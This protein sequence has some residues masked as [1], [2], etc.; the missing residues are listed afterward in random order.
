MYYKIGDIDGFTIPVSLQFKY[1][2]LGKLR[3]QSF[4]A[5][6]NCIVASWTRPPG[7]PL[8]QRCLISNSAGSPTLLVSHMK[9]LNICY[10]KGRDRVLTV[11]SMS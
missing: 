4:I 1:S 9:T 10:Q 8:F 3:K 11:Y 5:Y 6:D 2:E 7:T